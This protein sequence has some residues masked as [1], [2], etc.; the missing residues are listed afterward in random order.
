MSDFQL[1]ITEHLKDL[2]RC[3][4]NSLI[5][6]FI[7]TCFCMFFTND[8][9]NILKYPMEQFLKNNNSFIILMPHE[10]FFT[11]MKAALF[12]GI[13]ISSPWISYQIWSFVSPGLHVKEKKYSVIFIFLS[14]FFFIL[15]VLFGYLFV[16][17]VSFNFFSQGLPNDVIGNYSIPMLFSFSIKILIVFGI[18]FETPIIIFLLIFL[19]IIHIDFFIKH[20]KIV[21]IIAFL[22]AAILTPPDPLSQIMLAIPLILFFEIGILAARLFNKIKK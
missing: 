12:G 6:V 15:G 4:I 18:I 9:L 10:Y 17:P 8:F 1:T 11:Q 5:G 16:L 22:L 3:L 7:I 20:R 2:R 13:I 19:K 14:A 21:I